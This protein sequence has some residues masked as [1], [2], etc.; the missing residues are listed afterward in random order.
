MKF[1]QARILD[2]SPSP[3]GR[4]PEFRR[5]SEGT[6]ACPIETYTSESSAQE[7]QQNQQINIREKNE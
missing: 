5:E 1:S 2:P 4:A 6:K 7:F 3:E